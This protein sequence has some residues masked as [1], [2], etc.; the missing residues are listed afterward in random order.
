[1]NN[2]QK[3]EK[4][5]HFETLLFKVTLGILGIA[6]S[7]FIITLVVVTQIYSIPKLLIDITTTILM[8]TI[9]NFFLSIIRIFKYIIKISKLEN[10]IGIMRSV[11]SLLISPISA[12]ILLVLIILISLSGCTIQ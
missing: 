12:A 4:F 5:N 3:V 1:M 11:I 9:A 10:N 7:L 8:I 6:I 2:T